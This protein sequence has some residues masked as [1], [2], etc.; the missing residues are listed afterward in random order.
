MSVSA[1]VCWCWCV[2]V[3]VCVGAGVCWC[4]LVCVGVDVCWCW[5]V[6]VLMCVGAGVCWCW[7]MTYM[8]AQHTNAL[9]NR[10]CVRSHDLACLQNT[11]AIALQVIL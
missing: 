3:L 2:L 10:A 6:L 9:H 4:V 11:I 5:C 1:G 8:R 7:C